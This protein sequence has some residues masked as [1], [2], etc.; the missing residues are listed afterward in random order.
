MANKEIVDNLVKS[1]WMEI[2]TVISYI[3]N[4]INLDGV[5]AEEI[6]KSLAV[7]I[8]EELTHAQ[9]LA[10]R[11]KEVGGI[12]PGSFDFKAEH[13]FLQPVA[14]TTDVQT[15]IEGVLEAEEGAIKQYNKIIKLCDG[16]DYV[17]QD[18][19]I[20]LLAAEE[21]HKIEFQGFLKEYKK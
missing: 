21:S 13:K 1:Y 10:K 15:V 9:R 12:V 19:C 11:I 16:V 5:R 2:E 4:S 6:K 17:T 7:D 8:A 14:D 18:L 3:A 20:Q